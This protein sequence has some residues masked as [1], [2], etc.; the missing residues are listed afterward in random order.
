LNTR[1]ENSAAQEGAATLVDAAEATGEAAVGQADLVGGVAL[2]GLVD[3][4]GAA[5]D[6]QVP[7]AGRGAAEVDLGEPA[8]EGPGGRQ[9]DSG[10]VLGEDDADEFGSPFGVLAAE[11]LG[12]EEDGVGGEPPRGDRGAMVGGGRHGVVVAACPQ[13]QIL[14]GAEGEAEAPGEGL[15]VESLPLVGLPH[16]VPDPLAYRA[17]HGILPPVLVLAESL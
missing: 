1:G 15:V 11:G 4:G 10:E 14:D 5:V 17:R 3:G 7:P 16:G 9:R 6:G 13:E 8:L 12:P 2:P